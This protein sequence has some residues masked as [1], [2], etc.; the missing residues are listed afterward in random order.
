MGQVKRAREQSGD[1]R[2]VRGRLQRRSEPLG[3]RTVTA[4]S[5]QGLQDY[6]ET[7]RNEKRIV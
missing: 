7:Q 3:L 2:T 4:G 5:A 1:R 6:E